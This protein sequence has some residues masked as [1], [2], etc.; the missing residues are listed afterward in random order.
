MVLKKTMPM[1][2]KL[3]ERVSQTRVR[4]NTITGVSA[5]GDRTVV[6][7]SA[8]H[9]FK[10][11][12]NT[13]WDYGVPWPVNFK[14]ATQEVLKVHYRLS[15]HAAGDGAALGLGH[16]PP[17]VLHLIIRKAAGDRIDWID[18]QG[19]HETDV[20]SVAGLSRQQCF[21]EFFLN[22]VHVPPALVGGLFC[23]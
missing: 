9:V 4:L 19:G 13:S 6:V 18:E 12:V 22:N 7:S 1:Q 14:K 5:A 11:H 16:M 8:H 3:M 15:K 21:S 17:D 20:C 10:L 23:L 2:D